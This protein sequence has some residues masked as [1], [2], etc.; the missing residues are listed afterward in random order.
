MSEERGLAGQGE[1]VEFLAVLVQAADD[2]LGC[3]D[4]GTPL[5]AEKNRPVCA[6]MALSRPPPEEK[7]MTI[8]M[9]V[10]AA[11]SPARFA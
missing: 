11:V 2:Q 9:A 8:T 10:H 4:N 7:T 1:V 6:M 5:R 3:P